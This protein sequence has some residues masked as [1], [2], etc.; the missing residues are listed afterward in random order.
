MPSDCIIPLRNYWLPSPRNYTGNFSARCSVDSCQFEGYFENFVQPSG[1]S[2]VRTRN[3][4]Y[5]PS[6]SRTLTANSKDSGQS[7]CQ[8]WSDSMDFD[9]F[10]LMCD[11]SARSLNEGKFRSFRSSK[12]S[13]DLKT[14]RFLSQDQL[15]QRN[16][17]INRFGIENLNY[18]EAV[19]DESFDICPNSSGIRRNS[20]NNACLRWKM[21][22]FFDRPRLY[23]SWVSFWNR[24]VVTS[25]FENPTF[26]KVFSDNIE[27]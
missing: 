24:L 12:R 16:R 7:K 17:I 21:M 10:K 22:K 9:N 8:I 26:F 18:R 3:E 19:K 11:V 20:E 14:P 5:V 2:N 1:E 27:Q 13:T 4:E 15:S 25:V 23:K 6:I